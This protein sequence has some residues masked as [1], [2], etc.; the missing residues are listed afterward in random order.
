MAQPFNF[1]TPITENTLLIARYRCGTAPYAGNW[2][3]ATST[4]GNQYIPDSLEKAVSVAS[5]TLPQTK[6]NLINVANGRL[7]EVNPTTFIKIELGGGWSEYTQGTFFYFYSNTTIANIS[8]YAGG[9]TFSDPNCIMLYVYYTGSTA[10]AIDITGFMFDEHQWDHLIK[11]SGILRTAP[12]NPTST[13]YIPNNKGIYGV[14]Q[15]LFSADSVTYGNSYF[16][17]YTSAASLPYTLNYTEGTGFIG[18]YAQSWFDKFQ[19]I[20]TSQWSRRTYL[21]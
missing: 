14:V 6:V 11:P 1:N 16:A 2:F 9:L 7:E 19:T 17:A 3:R 5:M 15:P 13:Y 8:G 10:P 4:N 21:A 12:A 20:P 18:P